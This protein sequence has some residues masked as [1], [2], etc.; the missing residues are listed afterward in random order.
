[1][2]ARRPTHMWAPTRP[3]HM[4]SSTATGSHE[5]GHA[6]FRRVPEHP[7]AVDSTPWAPAGLFDPMDDEQRITDPFPVSGRALTCGDARSANGLLTAS[8]SGG[9][10]QSPRSSGLRWPFDSLPDTGTGVAFDA[11][12]VSLCAVFVPVLAVGGERLREVAMSPPDRVRVAPV[13]L[14]S[15][16]GASVSRRYVRQPEAAS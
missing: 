3:T 10:R 7:R 16:V 9:R 15:V 6:S 14:P 5:P 12:S 4:Y 2:S 1:M 13:R 8:A 11:V